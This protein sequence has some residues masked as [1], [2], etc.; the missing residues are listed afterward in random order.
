[1]SSEKTRGHD[2]TRVWSAVLYPESV[3][4]GWRDYLDYL[5]LEWVESPLHQYDV[6]ADG[7][8][9]KPHW[10]ILLAF[11][12]PKSYEQVRDM[13]SP[14]NGPVPQKCHAVRGA[15]RYMAHLDNPEKFQY[16]V[17]EIIAHGGF[18]LA[19]ALSPTAGQRYDLIGEM[20]DFVKDQCI[21]EFQDLF[22]YALHNRHDDWF[23]LLCD[24]SAYVLQLY[25]KSQRHRTDCRNAKHED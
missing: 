24:N 10:H 8:L 7:E 3:P 20:A 12:G 22:D 25:I 17:S 21:T 2:R 5:H 15:V 14:L 16:P 18:D 11:D 9:K 1:M 13:L 4:D 19:N 23:P 6:N